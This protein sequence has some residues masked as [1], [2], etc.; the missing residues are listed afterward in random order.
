MP[1]DI[2]LPL[3][4][5][6]SPLINFFVKEISLRKGH[7]I[8][9]SG[10]KYVSDVDD[11]HKRFQHIIRFSFLKI[12]TSHILLFVVPLYFFINRSKKKSYKRSNTETGPHK[13]SQN[14][15]GIVWYM[16]LKIESYCLKTSVKIRM[17]EKI[18]KNI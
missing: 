13:K 8:Q 11:Y 2:G 5:W 6:C 1:A 7:H 18:C 15:I 16:C 12:H 3:L 4:V 14:Y 17:D 10:I 9:L